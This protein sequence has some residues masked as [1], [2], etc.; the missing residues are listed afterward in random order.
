MSGPEIGFLQ[1]AQPFGFLAPV[2]F[3]FDQ[4]GVLLFGKG[5]VFAVLFE[6]VG[7]MPPADG[8]TDGANTQQDYGPKVAER[9][10]QR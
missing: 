3:L 1:R 6:Q 4:P 9:R 2:R 8:E 10:A 5:T 7:V